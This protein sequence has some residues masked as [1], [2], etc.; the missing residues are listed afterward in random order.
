MNTFEQK[1]KTARRNFRTRLLIAGLGGLALIAVILPLA[2]FAQVAQV[3]PFRIAP[4]PAAD[5]AEVSVSEGVGVVIFDAAY[6]LGER[7]TLQFAARGFVTQA[8]EVD[9]AQ[10]SG[11]LDVVLQAAPVQVVITTTPSLPQ[12]R[13]HVNGA[14]V[15]TAAQFSGEMQPPPE[16]VSITADHEFYQMQTIQVELQVGTDFARNL[17]LTP[18][19]GSIRVQSAPVGA[20]VEFDGEIRGITP[21]TLGA[22]AGG[23]HRLRVALP[24][25]ETIEEEIAV[26]NKLPDV[27]RDYRL[28]LQRATAHVSVSPAGGVLS[29]NGVPVSAT[30]PLSLSAGESHLVRYEK[31]GYLPQSRE[32]RVPLGDSAPVEI[33]FRLEAE[34]GEVV[35]RAEPPAELFINDQPRGTTP[36][37]AKLQALPHKITLKRSGYRT[38][39]RMVTPNSASRILIDETLQ[40]EAAARLAEA[41]PTI[42]AAAGVAMK[43]FDPRTHANMPFTM[44]AP[45]NDRFRRADEFQRTVK[46]TRPFYVS[47]REITEAQF[48]RYKPI[49]V[50]GK[51]YP[52]RGIS[53]LE[54]A[55][56]ANWMSA[57]DGLRP[58]YRI[59][60]GRLRD[61]D[62]DADG[63]RLPS[64]AEWEWLARAAGRAEVVRFVWG[65]QTTIPANSGNF[66]DESAKGSVPAYI[67]RY[68][69]GFAGV[70]PVASFTPDAA[71]LYDMAGNVSEWVHD[72]YDLRRPVAGQVEIDPFGG[73]GEWAGEEGSRVVKGANFRSASITAL[74]ASFREGLGKRR[75][76]VGFR[77][78]RY[79][80]EE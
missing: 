36:Q 21:L 26:T 27:A 61:F 5:H 72:R 76:D 24:G 15:A 20:S 8:V 75:D 56:F 23:V 11:L 43:L 16:V 6:L 40:T 38:L 66:A 10:D 80:Y 51:G 12:T 79:L 25:Y 68:Q 48:A 42:T 49:Q 34:I 67:P 44:G 47:T 55:G 73:G 9:A 60:D 39:E 71:G 13:W 7:A 22:V 54:A 3:V 65:N 50:S 78:V 45:I 17:E 57:Q 53:W 70:A 74:R 64:E 62:A 69:D 2:Y 77:V 32:V 46:L 30:A 14:F 29:V 58:A 52:V 28:K 4:Q 31:A 19:D 63:Y 1:L 18:V 35:I 59:V 33:S 41:A 37:T